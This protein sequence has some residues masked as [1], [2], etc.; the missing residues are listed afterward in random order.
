MDRQNRSDGIHPNMLNSECTNRTIYMDVAKGLGMIFVILGHMEDPTIDRFIFSF[1]MPMFFL[2]SGYFQS[3]EQTPKEVI[4]K[5]CKQLGRPYL[6]T[7]AAVIV[8]S[9]ILDTIYF[10]LGKRS[11]IEIARNAFRWIYA[12]FWGSGA[13]HEVP[14][15]VPAI[16][17][18]WFLLALIWGS[19]LTQ[20]ARQRR[21][22]IIW[23]IGIAIIGYASSQVIW[24]PWSIQPAM[25][26]T[27]F[28]YIGVLL[29]DYKII[30]KDRT[31][32]LLCVLIVIWANEIAFG[33]PH[34]S[35]TRNLYPNGV[36]DF[37]GGAPA[38]SLSFC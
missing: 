20:Y 18:I 21:Y 27:V 12:S 25:T 36:F 6:Y 22:P 35:M 19:Y 17:A 30:E 33:D 14:V 7:C 5:R 10:L 13:H 37:I 1:H 32:A 3:A 29:R 4:H 34:I 15:D 38:Q 9:F 8:L 31:G 23:I 24:L 26:A 2:I 11:G 28:I 16:G